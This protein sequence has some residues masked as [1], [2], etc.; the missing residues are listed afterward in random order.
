MRIERKRKRKGEG[1]KSKRNQG[2]PH[3]TLTFVTKGAGKHIF[4]FPHLFDKI[5]VEFSQLFSLALHTG[6]VP[7]H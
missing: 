3:S 1:S 4:P 6:A 5:Y 2:I 7:F